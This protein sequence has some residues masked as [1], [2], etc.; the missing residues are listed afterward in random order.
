MEGVAMKRFSAPGRLSASLSLVSSLG[1]LLGLAGP[2]SAQREL[3]TPADLKPIPSGPG[4]Q[5]CEPVATG[6]DA[7]LADFGSGCGLWL[8][9]AMGFH[10]QLGQTPRWEL[11]GRAHKELQTPRLRLSLAQG[12]KLYN[13][14]GV[15]HIAIGK[16]TGTPAH[17]LLTYQLYSVPAQKAIGAPIKLAGTEE[18]VLAQLPQAA[19]TLLTALGVQK[20]NVPAGV[21]ASPAEITT[22]GHY[23]WYEDQKPTTAEQQ[24][25]DTLGKKIPLARLLSYARH[26]PQNVDERAKLALHLLEQAS[27]NF[28]M[29]GMVA[30]SDDQFSPELVRP[31][32][33][34]VAALAAPNNA[35]LAYWAADRATSPPEALKAYERTVR[36][37]PHSSTAW[38]ILALRYATQGDYIRRARVAA[39]LTPQENKKIEEIYARWYY[40]ATQAATLDA[41][42]QD[43][44]QGLATA[45]TFIGDP[46]RADDA[47]WKAVHLNPRNV[48]IYEWGLEMYQ[49]KWGG[50]PATLAKV[51]HLAMTTA[52]PPGADIYRLGVELESAGFPTQ[53]K[54]MYARAIAQE[55]ILV[56]Q[57]PKDANVHTAL[58]T[59][60][61]R[62]GHEAEAETE[63]KT[64]LRLDPSASLARA[65][66]DR[67]YRKHNRTAD[68]VNLLRTETQGAA[69]VGA[70]TALAETLIH[71]S[72]DEK[73]DE[74]QKMLNEVLKVQ[75]NNYRANED[76]AWILARKKQYD[77]ALKVYGVAAKLKPTYDLPHREMGRIYRLQSKFDAAIREG[78][79]AVTL[80]PRSHTTL[81]SLA[82]TYAAKGDNDKSIQLYRKAIEAAPRSAPDHM[83]FGVFLLKIGKKA[84][85]RAELKHVLEL[86]APPAMKKSAQDLLDKNP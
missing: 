58:G 13:I 46:V 25:I 35:V 26:R 14:L 39:S 69:N 10:P 18:Q 65:N 1:L 67:L 82:A 34:Q 20:L 31:M 2:A 15:T 62:Q 43:A 45:A 84:E 71:N 23:P 68:S 29:V 70:K 53:A 83:E 38:Y 4:I 47:F 73:Y 40:A 32:D 36:L 49:A 81:S 85:G 19:R 3:D 55:R 44:W 16:I 66:L 75:P 86:N 59:Y 12:S 63:L 21:G 6:H 24:Q 74:P 51:V 48:E 79:L 37:A 8:Q 64:A 33:T 57:Y 27:G 11:A 80:A 5:V 42:S 61:S 78:E 41:D 60:L 28:L 17:C 54:T 56:R 22:I 9:W 76:L 30:T 7:A 77:P 72:K 50:N 52:F